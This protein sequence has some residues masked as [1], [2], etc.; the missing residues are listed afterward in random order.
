MEQLIRN[1]IPGIKHYGELLSQKSI[2]QKTWLLINDNEDLIQYTF[3]KGGELI[4]SINGD[5]LKGK[6]ELLSSTKILLDSP[7]GSI[8]LENLFFNIGIIVLLKPSKVEELFILIDAN[9]IIDRNP[10]E[11]LKSIENSIDLNLNQNGWE[12]NISKIIYGVLVFIMLI[13]IIISFFTS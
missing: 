2:L 8:Q 12:E 10:L 7:N 9:V 4:I 5:V 6:W 3:K 13:F 11:Y 1:I